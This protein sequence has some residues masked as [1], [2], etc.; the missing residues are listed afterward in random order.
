MKFANYY[1]IYTFYL[2]QKN[3]KII[4]NIIFRLFFRKKLKNNFKKKIYILR[5]I[6]FQTF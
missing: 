2:I 6:L 5:Y 3:F 4:K 1:K